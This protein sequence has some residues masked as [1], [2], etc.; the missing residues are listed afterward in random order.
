MQ[1]I[2]SL[3]WIYSIRSWADKSSW[4]HAISTFMLIINNEIVG[5]LNL[6]KFK[7]IIDLRVITVNG[8]LTLNNKIESIE[9][10]PT[11]TIATNEVK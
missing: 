5:I 6:L 11:N 3:P 2:F 1:E 4:T 8:F 7:S 9:D 10:K